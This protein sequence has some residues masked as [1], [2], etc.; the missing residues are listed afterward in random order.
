MLNAITPSTAVRAAIAQANDALRKA[1]IKK[2]MP[3][4]HLLTCTSLLTR[5][6]SANRFPTTPKDPQLNIVPL[7]IAVSSDG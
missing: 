2:V 1:F 6:L 5:H 7:V 3:E 4:S